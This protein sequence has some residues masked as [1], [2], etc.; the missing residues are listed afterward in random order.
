MN[1]IVLLALSQMEER[2]RLINQYLQ[3]NIRILEKEIH[4]K[5]KETETT[6][7]VTPEEVVE[8]QEQ[9]RPETEGNKKKM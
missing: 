8:E 2:E 5:A 6:R 4:E 9:P 3:L 7:Q 1:H